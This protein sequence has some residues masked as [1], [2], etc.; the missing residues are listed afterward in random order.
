MRALAAVLIVASL[1]AWQ[2]AHA[3]TIY[4]AVGTSGN[5]P[6]P[7]PIHGIYDF[8]A[9]GGGDNDIY[10]G[11]LK[12]GDPLSDNVIPLSVVTG[13]FVRCPWSNDAQSLVAVNAGTPEDFSCEDSNIDYM[14]AHGKPNVFLVPF[15]DSLSPGTPGATA[16]AALPND[17]VAAGGEH[18]DIINSQARCGLPVTYPLPWGTNF[19]TMWKAHITHLVAHL[20]ATNRIYA[21]K[22]VAISGVSADTGEYIMQLS[23]SGDFGGTGTCICADS[24]NTACT[25]GATVTVPDQHVQWQTLNGTVAPGLGYTRAKI[26]AA[27]TDMAAF[28]KATWPAGTIFTHMSGYGT[29]EDP[30]GSGPFNDAFPDID[31]AGNLNYSDPNLASLGGNVLLTAAQ[32]VFGTSFMAQSNDLHGGNTISHG[33]ELA[34]ISSNLLTGGG[35]AMQWGQTIWKSQ[36]VINPTCIMNGPDLTNGCTGL[37][38]QVRGQNVLLDYGMQMSIAHP[39]DLLWGSLPAWVAFLKGYYQ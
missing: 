30:T 31:D 38:E 15:E 29:S 19:R 18:L 21:V 20:T 34:I 2:A 12:N 4:P 13:A 24:T 14:I 16:A 8:V 33:R 36:G 35:A 37:G 10:G 11:G 39:E 1:L 7:Y 9:L 5:K 32:S 26:V 22:E 23:N 25:K 17:Y 28:Y 6:T 27:Y 3:Q